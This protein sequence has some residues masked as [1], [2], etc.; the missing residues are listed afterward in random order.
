MNP[1]LNETIDE[2]DAG[3]FMQQVEAALKEVALGVIRN[4]KKKGSVTL[5]LELDRIGESDSV[6]VNHTLKFN[7]PTR[8]GKATEEMTTSTLMYVNNLGYL[9]I[10]PQTQDDLFK[11]ENGNNVARFVG[12][13]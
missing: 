13:K 9:T 12:A 10:S 7:K 11:Q 2:L 4:D 1:T 6:T 3:L 8:R 5:V